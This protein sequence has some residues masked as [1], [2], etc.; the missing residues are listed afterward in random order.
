MADNIYEYEF[1]SVRWKNHKK[2]KELGAMGYRIIERIP[3]PDYA[4]GDFFVLERVR[5]ITNG[6]CTHEPHKSI[7]DLYCG[8]CG[9]VI[10]ENRPQIVEDTMVI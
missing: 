9:K 3:Y 4:G 10:E 8:T 7:G 1:E 2:I 6:D 5:E